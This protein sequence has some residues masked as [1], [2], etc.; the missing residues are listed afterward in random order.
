MER[1]G[2]VFL[3]IKSAL[4]V[5][6]LILDGGMGTELY[7]RGIV[8]DTELAN[9]SDGSSVFEIHKSYVEAGVDII[10]A[11]TFGAYSH[12]HDNFAELIK[13]AISHAKK[14]CSTC[15]ET[16]RKIW[17]A[18][19]MGPTG[20]V[21]EPYGEASSDECYG[22]F[23]SAA[24]T[25]KE[26]GADLIIVETMM[27]LNELKLAVEAAKTTNLPIFASMSFTEKGRTMY[28]ASVRDMATTLEQLGVDAIGMNCGFGPES[29]ASLV[30]ELIE[31]TTLPTLLQPNA[32]IPI[33][34]GAGLQYDVK[35]ESFA[36]LMK[37]MS[38]YGVQVLG[39]CCGTEPAHIA[40]VARLIKGASK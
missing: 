3:D 23:K 8:G 37:K 28:G 7:K 34:G 6:K 17:V 35:P 9:L 26:A 32:G 11:N 40:A 31:I 4:K 20:L 14:A 1:L 24:Q 19:D 22:I 27:D 21:L 2:V 5:G 33:A 30:N 39:G 25:G 13:V 29:Y 16:G 10:T 36:Q 38:D 12:K 18:L 15:G